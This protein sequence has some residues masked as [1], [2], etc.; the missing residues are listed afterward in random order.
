M[1]F[2]LFGSCG[3]LWFITVFVSLFL[4]SNPLPANWSHCLQQHRTQHA[5]LLG[6]GFWWILPIQELQRS[7]KPAGWRKNW[8]FGALRVYLIFL[9]PFYLI[10]L[11]PWP[12]LVPRPPTPLFRSPLTP[13]LLS[14]C[15]ARPILSCSAPGCCFLS[16][17]GSGPN[18]KGN[19]FPG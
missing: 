18:Q 9:P 1:V 10:F 8:L 7:G 6:P 17:H 12:F 3:H 5:N 4:C 16:P 11:P 13:S 14:V 2:C 15:H 19:R